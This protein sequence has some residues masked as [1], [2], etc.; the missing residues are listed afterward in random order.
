MELYY[1]FPPV[2][3]IPE[4]RIFLHINL[5]HRYKYKKILY[6]CMSNYKISKDYRHSEA[7][8]TTKLTYEFIPKPDLEKDNLE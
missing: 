2:S 7:K 6:I 8:K 5:W 3:T 1:L 4:Y